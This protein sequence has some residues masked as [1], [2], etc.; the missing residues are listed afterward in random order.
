MKKMFD[1]GNQIHKF[2]SSSGSG[3]DFLTSYGS[4]STSQKVTVPTVPVPKHCLVV[5]ST[6]CCGLL[7]LNLIDC[8]LIIIVFCCCSQME[9]NLP[10]WQESSA[11]I[12]PYSRVCSCTKL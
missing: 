1:E 6:L 2:M 5:G 4:G 11:V 9:C 7:C 10:A 12:S 3:S 8:L